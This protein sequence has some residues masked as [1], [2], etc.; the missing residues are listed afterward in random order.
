MTILDNDIIE[1]SDSYY[2][3]VSINYNSDTNEYGY[4]RF[5]GFIEKFLNIV[6]FPGRGYNVYYT[7]PDY[8]ADP[9]ALS[10]IGKSYAKNKEVVCKDVM[11]KLTNELN[12]SSDTIR[13]IA[14]DFLSG[15][16]LQYVNKTILAQDF[17]RR[18]YES[19]TTVHNEP[20]KPTEL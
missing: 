16:D 8:E 5:V 6:V 7:I 2:H 12:K 10:H 13:L 14:S 17:P 15:G 1:Y 19:N 18:M 9:N 4:I 11:E 3:R 20:M